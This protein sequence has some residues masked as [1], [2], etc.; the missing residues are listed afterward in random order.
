MDNARKPRR[1]NQCRL[2][3]RPVCAW[4]CGAALL[5]VLLG[6]HGCANPNPAL[7]PDVGRTLRQAEP[8]ELQELVQQPPVPLKD[9]PQEPSPEEVKR[10]RKIVSPDAGT[11]T[12]PLSL[13]DVRLA[14][15]KNNLDLR[16][17]E[18]NPALAFEDYRAEFGKFEAV[19]APTASHTE[20]FDPQGNVLVTSSIG[21]VVR[22]PDRAGGT[23]TLG[24]PFTHN[25]GIGVGPFGGLIAATQ[26]GVGTPLGTTLFPEQVNL[27]LGFSQPLL[28]NA[29]FRLNY[30]SINV[31]GLT[32]RQVDARTKLLAI[33]VLA[34]AEQAYWRYYAAYAL[35]RIAVQQYEYAVEQLRIARRLVQE[36]ILTSIEITRAEANASTR[37]ATIIQ[38]ELTRRLAQ[39]ALLRMINIPDLPVETQTIVIPQTP[40]YPVGFRFEREKVLDLALTTRMELVDNNLQMAINQY[41]LFITRNAILPDVRFDFKYS[42]IGSGSTPG[43]AFDRLFAQ[44]FD[45]YNMLLAAEI[46]LSGNLP[47]SARYRAAR[48]RTAQTMVTRQ[49]LELGIRETVLNSMDSVEENWQRLLANR[50][51]VLHTQENYQANLKQFQQKLIT[52]NELLV[53]QGQLADA[54]SNL[55]QNLADYQNSLVDLAFATGT[56]LGIS[57]G[58]WHSPYEANGPGDGFCLPPWPDATQIAPLAPGATPGVPGTPDTLGA[59]RKVPVPNG[60]Q[61]PDKA[62]PGP[63]AGNDGKRAALPVSATVPAMPSS[64]TARDS[65]GE[66]PYM[67]IGGNGRPAAIGAPVLAAPTAAPPQRP[68][69]SAAPKPE[70]VP[71][72]VPTANGEAPVPDG[73]ASD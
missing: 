37:F 66:S 57:G 29:G 12:S 46:P 27:D 55:V 20:T 61:E 54:E 16:V 45:T 31:L 52:G 9:A 51:A 58:I 21:P 53:V 43:Q 67:P 47:A 39:R 14:A 22:I 1:G 17:Q 15:L 49:Q 6:L 68:A 70:A 8:L 18:F 30:A 35:L 24:M 69:V 19:F 7:A 63:A 38:A 65:R 59:P 36:G 10:A 5:L 34:N 2:L 11:P 64:Q 23:F 25:A 56:T 4:G 44:S 62:P 41:N 48:L 33:Q 42:F 71:Q 72:Q 3:A 50:A 60:G 40:P 32:M 73:R 26:G 13:P 28:R